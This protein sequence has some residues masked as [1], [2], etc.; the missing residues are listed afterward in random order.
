MFPFFNFFVCINKVQIENL[1]VSHFKKAYSLRQDDR[2]NHTI[3]LSRTNFPSLNSENVFNLTNSPSEMEI[4]NAV[5]NL[6]P[7]KTPGEDGLHAILYQ[8]N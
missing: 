7:L 2:R 1:L 5:Y 6:N 8:T 4:K 3:T